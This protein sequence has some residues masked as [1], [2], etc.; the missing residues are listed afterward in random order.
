MMKT[1]GI[2]PFGAALLLASAMTVSLAQ[3]NSGTAPEQKGNTGWTGGSSDQPS[4]S[5]G[6]Q[7]KAS[8]TTGQGIGD[9]AY[10]AA[11]DAESAKTQ[12]LT[13]TGEDLNGPPIRFPANKTPE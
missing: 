10:Q 1:L 12:P 2:I 5:G 9:P 11:R 13:A 7:N 4:Q 6:S 3:S 8:G